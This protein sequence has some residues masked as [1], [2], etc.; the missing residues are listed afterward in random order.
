MRKEDS[1]R[2]KRECTHFGT[3]FHWHFVLWYECTHFRKNF[4]WSS[5]VWFLLKTRNLISKSVHLWIS[6]AVKVIDK[7]QGESSDR[8]MLSFHGHCDQMRGQIKIWLCLLR[9]LFMRKHQSIIL[10]YD[11]FRFGDRAV[12]PIRGCLAISILVVV[13]RIEWKD[14]L[15]YT[16][17]KY[18]GRFDQVEIAANIF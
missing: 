14:L 16:T 11:I 13:Y 5:E 18:M 6:C 1:N 12:K 7:N 3:H 8:F 10:N 17:H 2:R 4:Y 9:E 15:K